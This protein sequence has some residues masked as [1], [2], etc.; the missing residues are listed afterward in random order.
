MYLAIEIKGE[1]DSLMLW[2]LI[3]SHKLNL[4]QADGKCWVYGEANYT[5]IGEVVSRCA[6]FGNLTAEITKGGGKSEQ[7]KKEQGS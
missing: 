1:V 5:V 4:L 7:E 6:L 3:K 2:E